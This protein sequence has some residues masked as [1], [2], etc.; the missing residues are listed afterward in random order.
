MTAVD[1]GLLYDLCSRA[2]IVQVRSVSSEAGLRG[3]TDLVRRAT[4]CT[5]TYSHERVAAMIE[6]APRPV[7]FR[8]GAAR[9]EAVSTA[10]TTPPESWSEDERHDHRA[11]QDALLRAVG[12]DSGEPVAGPLGIARNVVEQLLLRWF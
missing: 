6:S 8:Y 3:L 2:R 7:G 12:R 5:D 11:A 10:R 4:G 9:V 1:E